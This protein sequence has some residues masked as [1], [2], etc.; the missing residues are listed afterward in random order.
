MMLRSFD[1]VLRWLVKEPAQQFQ[2]SKA[3]QGVYLYGAGE[4]GK[5]ALDYCEAC[6]TPV[7]AFLDK[8]GRAPL[9]SK[10]GN[11]YSVI[12]PDS[13][14]DNH[15]R[16][17]LVLVAV[18]THSY[19]AI[20]R[21]LESLGWK[22]ISPFYA[23]TSKHSADH[24]LQNG[25]RLGTVSDHEIN[26][27]R[28]ICELWPDEQSWDHYEAFLAWHGASAETDVIV[29]GI[30]TNQRYG[31]PEV[32]AALQSR[33]R[34]FIDVGSHVGESIKRTNELGVFFD[35]YV[36]FEPDPAS[37][38]FLKQNVKNLIPVS[39]KVTLNQC[40]LADARQSVKYQAG[41]GYCSQIWEQSSN[42]QE[43]YDLDRFEL[44][45][46]F[47]KVHTEGSE[48]LI[49]KGARATIQRSRPVIAY[50]V[51]HRREGF[52]SDIFDVI[53][54][55]SGYKWYFRL[56]SYQGTGA[57]VYGIPDAHH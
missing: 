10:F 47:L 57:F 31:I 42:S 23:L 28:S 5:L 51:Y 44:N 26:I 2:L 11:E 50:S 39:A 15:I 36:L 52:Y 46:D 25:W 32:L 3:E 40:V 22:N 7:L 17:K 48:S 6:G 37:L 12:Y 56:H 9:S 20:H 4:L 19:W 24:P 35:D 41:L 29:S 38:T 30:N 43:A 45:P 55:F 1:S 49:L 33:Q 21:E 8:M 14:E 27:V 18:A 34:Q 53:S 16:E 13:I 54:I